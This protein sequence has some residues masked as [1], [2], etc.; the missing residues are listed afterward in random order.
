MIDF[1]TTAAGRPPPYHR[2][3]PDPAMTRPF[4]RIPF[5]TLLTLALLPLLAGCEVGTTDPDP[6]CLTIPGGLL[7]RTQADVDASEGVCAIEG[8]LEIRQEVGTDDP[9]TTL[10]P[11][12]DLRVIGTAEGSGLRVQW[13]T[14]LEGLDGLEGVTMTGP[15]ELVIEGNAALATLGALGAEGE[16]GVRRLTDVRVWHNAALTDLVGIGHLLASAGAEVTGELSL[17]GNASLSSLNGL[18]GITGV[19]ERLEIQSN[20]SLTTLA[21]LPH[22]LSVGTMRLID[23]PMTSLS[24][25]LQDV[26]D[27]L[28]IERNPALATLSIDAREV[29]RNLTVGQNWVLESLAVE[30]DRAPDALVVYQNYEMEAFD[31]ALAE[32]GLG[33]LTLGQAPALTSLGFDDVLVQ[34]G[35]ALYGTGLADLDAFTTTPS[36]PSSFVLVGNP[37]L[38]DIGAFAALESTGRLQV[39]DNAALCVPAW[40]HDVAV[41]GSQ[42]AVISG[43]L[44]D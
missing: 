27:L 40:V 14:R 5:H 1:L 8:A 36:L 35:L 28:V 39:E 25:V 21:G 18:A 11:L 37:D 6:E 26:R 12:S 4:A 10:A 3:F 42:P 23:L 13:T 38:A 2:R 33:T 19:V 31:L 43:N 32:G 9:I 24:L 30:L 41:T 15:A 44:C 16:G 29:G 34:A 7:L 20:P 22:A 17:Y